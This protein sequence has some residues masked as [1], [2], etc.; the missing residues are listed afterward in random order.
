MDKNALLKD[1]LCL[2][3]CGVAAALFCLFMETPQGARLAK[4]VVW[5]VGTGVGIFF[6]CILLMLVVSC[7]HTPSGSA[8][9]SPEASR[10]RRGAV[11]G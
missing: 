8:K 1:R 4:H 10:G 9:S 5:L 2:L 3:A 11:R 6:L 7:F